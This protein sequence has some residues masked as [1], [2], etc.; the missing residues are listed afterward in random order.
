[1]W[2]NAGG[3]SIKS[4]RIQCRITEPHSGVS[5]CGYSEIE[6]S[7]R[8]SVSTIRADGQMISVRNPYRV[9]CSASRSVYALVPRSEN[10]SASS[11]INGLDK[12][13]DMAECP[14]QRAGVQ[15][16]KYKVQ[17]VK[18]ATT[19][20]AIRNWQFAMLICNLS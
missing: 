12:A 1:M 6:S 15:K 20:A 10:V 14:H 13:E 3:S 18:S 2:I 7:A 11:R 9:R 5:R 4:C 17:N 19:P 16:A 8:L